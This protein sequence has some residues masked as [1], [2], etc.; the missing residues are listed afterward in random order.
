[1]QVSSAVS[2][3]A[4]AGSVPSARLAALPLPNVARAV[5]VGLVAAA[6]VAGFAATSTQAASAT[7]ASAGSELTYLLRA[8]ALLKTLFAGAATGAVLWRLAVP[9]TWPRLGAYAA[10]CAA[11]AA[12]PGLIWSMAH[13]QAGAV[14]LH[15]GLFATVII[16]W[17]DPATANRMNAA[18]AARRALHRS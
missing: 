14:L 1:M 5:I 8:M 7:G 11:M 9:V 3:S 13:V 16:L 17:R 4:S 10:G 18:V 2:S 15:G 12:S 6:A